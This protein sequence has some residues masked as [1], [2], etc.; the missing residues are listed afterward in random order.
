MAIVLCLLWGKAGFEKHNVRPRTQP[1]ARAGL[2]PSLLPGKIAVMKLLILMLTFSSQLVLADD[3]IDFTLHNLSGEA[4]NLSDYR[5][6]WVVVNYWATWCKPCRKEIP[7]LAELHDSREDVTVLGI[8]Y[9]DTDVASIEAFLLDYPATF[10]IL[11]VDVF[12]PPEELEVPKVL[13]TTFVVDP[14]GV[15]VERF[16]GPVTLESLEQSLASA[17][18]AP[19]ASAN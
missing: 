8:A 15:I 18:A 13:P 4:V 19:E 3:G 14:A 5:G 10:P 12:E 17:A 9:E 2:Y 7:D 6:H 11:T 1:L 16:T